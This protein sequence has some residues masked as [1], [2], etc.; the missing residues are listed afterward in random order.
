MEKRR[1]A[2]LVWAPVLKWEL[3]N[4]RPLMVVALGKTVRQTLTYLAQYGLVFP[5]IVTVQ[6]YSYVALRPRGKQGPMHPERVKEYDDEFAEVFK[7]FN[8]IKAKNEHV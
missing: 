4:S 6:H 1:N 2:A 5:N 3:D 7:M 8:A